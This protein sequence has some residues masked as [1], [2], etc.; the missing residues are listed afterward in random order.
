MEACRQGHK[1]VVEVLLSAGANLNVIDDA[2]CVFGFFH[3]LL[4]PFFLIFLWIDRTFSPHMG[5][6]YGLPGNY[7]DIIV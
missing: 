7:K 3:F 5:F 1:E 2:V 6:C 4:L